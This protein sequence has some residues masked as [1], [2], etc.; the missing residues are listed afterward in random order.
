MRPGRDFIPSVLQKPIFLSA[1]LIDPAFDLI[2]PAGC[3][4]LPS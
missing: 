4:I 3:L 1:C 2:V